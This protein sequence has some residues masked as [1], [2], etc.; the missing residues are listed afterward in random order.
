LIQIKLAASVK[1]R[2]GCGIFNATNPEMIAPAV[3]KDTWLPTFLSIVIGF[4]TRQQPVRARALL[5]LKSAGS[6]CRKTESRPL[7]RLL[8]PAVL[9]SE[10]PLAADATLRIG[11]ELELAHRQTMKK[12]PLVAVRPSSIHGQGVFAL[13]DI[14]WGVKIIQ[15]CG[16]LISDKEA[17]RRLDRG[18]D[19]IFDL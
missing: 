19:G 15:Y 7:R 4:Q 5:L 17:N 14:P 10:R 2:S 13:R 18:A 12:H 16:E 3:Y 11:L 1:I 6:N 8:H 9:L